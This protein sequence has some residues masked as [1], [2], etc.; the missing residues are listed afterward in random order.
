MVGR[1]GLVAELGQVHAEMPAAQADQPPAVGQ[2]VE[3]REQAA[4]IGELRL[5]AIR[6]GLVG[7]ELHG[8]RVIAEAV[9]TGR[10][11]AAAAPGA[12]R[13]VRSV[14]AAHRA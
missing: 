11:E 12:D 4:E 10:L 6:V 9:A 5:A 7:R 1:G 14:Y 2:P 8:M 13:L 3:H